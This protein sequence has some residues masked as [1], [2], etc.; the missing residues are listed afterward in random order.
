[1]SVESAEELYVKNLEK[2]IKGY[3]LLAGVCTQ[4]GDKR[5]YPGSIYCGTG[6]TAR[7]EAHEPLAFKSIEKER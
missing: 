6:C 3:R 5:A 4:C 7:S 2:A 1:M